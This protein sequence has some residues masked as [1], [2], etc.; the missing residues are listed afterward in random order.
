VAVGQDR[1]VW[2]GPDFAMLVEFPS[3]AGGAASRM[4]VSYDDGAPSETYERLP[5]WTPP[6]EW[7]A[8]LVGRYRSP[9][10]DY[11]WTL[12]LDAGG[13]L[14]VRAPTIDER[15]LEPFRPGEFLLRHEKYPGVPA[16]YWVRFHE[17]AG[18]EIG[19]LT[20]WAPRLMNHRFER[21]RER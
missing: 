4:I 5:A 13:T 20:V 19:H 3:A 12:S 17:T 21:V 9:H 14:V 18:S 10:L 11:T 15:R 1:F 2:K 8:R 16:H 6:R 7:L